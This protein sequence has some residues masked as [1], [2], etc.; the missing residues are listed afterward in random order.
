[1][2][3]GRQPRA[4][5]AL[6]WLAGIGLALAL[7]GCGHARASSAAPTTTPV[8]PPGQVALAGGAYCDNSNSAVTHPPSDTTTT[9]PPPATPTT[10]TTAA[11]NV[12]PPGYL[13]NLRALDEVCNT[14]W[15]QN[16]PTDCTALADLVIPDLATHNLVCTAT[17]SQAYPQLCAAEA[18]QL[19]QMR[20]EQIVKGL[21]QI[22][23]FYN[24]NTTTTTTQPCGP[25]EYRLGLCSP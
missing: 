6:L 17:T 5:R 8:C 21:Q 11:P 2:R 25:S 1:M 3:R 24:P 9:T 7:A 23:G 19:Q 15:Q 13:E 10:K 22:P 18:S 4:L 12:P 16:D 14:Y 20:N